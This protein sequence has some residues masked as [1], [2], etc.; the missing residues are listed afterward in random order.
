MSLSKTN[1]KMKI[2]TIILQISFMSLMMFGSAIF[3]QE[4]NYKLITKELTKEQKVL[5]QKE[6]EI[7]KAN[8]DAFKATLT[9]E[10]LAILKDKTISRSEVRLRLMKTFTKTQKDLV[11]NQ[12]V[13]LRKTRESFRKTLTREQR[14]MLKERIDKIR[15]AKDRGELKNGPRERNSDG[16]KTRPKKN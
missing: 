5:L 14:K 8:R 3:A 10:Q 13:R 12:Q 7:M 9:K 2:K 16:R 6:R 4:S 1:K 11:R 15:K